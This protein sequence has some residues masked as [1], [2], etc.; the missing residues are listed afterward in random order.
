MRMGDTNDGGQVNF[1]GLQAGTYRLRFSADAVTPF[2]RE[3]TLTRGQVANLDITLTPAP[4]PKEVRVPAPASAPAKAPVGPAGQPQALSLYDMAEKELAGKQPRREILVSCSGN[5]RSTMV[6]LVSQDQPQRIYETA[7]VTYYVLGGQ[8]TI[9]IGGADHMLAAGGYA[10][11]PRGVPF[12]ITR[13][14]RTPLSLLSVL[15]GEPCEEAK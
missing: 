14:G 15:S 1:P 2:E 6:L 5:T 13:R 3:V 4:P 10:S 9:R 8:A 12:A 11:V 7:E